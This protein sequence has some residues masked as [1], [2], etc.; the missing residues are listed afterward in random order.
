MSGK[1]KKILKKSQLTVTADIFQLKL[2]S[3]IYILL[4]GNF[5]IQRCTYH[6]TSSLYASRRRYMSE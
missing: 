4:L 6:I 3:A 1:L 2:I 5:T